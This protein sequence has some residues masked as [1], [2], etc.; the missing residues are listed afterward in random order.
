MKKKKPN[1]IEEIEY[2]LTELR[3]AVLLSETTKNRLHILRELPAAARASS[4]PNSWTNDLDKDIDLWT[5][6]I[7]EHERDRLNEIR[8]EL[9]DLEDEEK[10]R[11]I[12]MELD[13]DFHNTTSE[14][15][16]IVFNLRAQAIIPIEEHEIERIR[17]TY[18]DDKQGLSQSERIK[19]YNEAIKSLTGQ[20]WT[21][22]RNKIAIEEAEKLLMQEIEDFFD[23]IRTEISRTDG[24]LD[25]Q[26]ERC[27]KAQQELDRLSVPER[28]KQ[29]F[30]KEIQ[31]RLDSIAWEQDTIEITNH[32]AE[33]DPN[34]RSV[35]DMKPVYE[36][37]RRKL[38]AKE[39]TNNTEKCRLWE[40]VE[41]WLNNFGRIEES[42]RL[43]KIKPEI[44]QIRDELDAPSQVARTKEHLGELERRCIN[45]VSKLNPKHWKFCLAEKL[46]DE[47]EH[48][49]N[50]IVIEVIEIRRNERRKFSE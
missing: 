45:L 20:K 35:P 37:V 13:N 32:R 24:S 6:A 26:K 19:S 28:L 3:V 39:W 33:L 29:G 49:K 12:V 44:D 21:A 38:D 25:M 48:L 27:R 8:D 34:G 4:Q 47:A 17:T 14:N 9:E 31:E 41:N 11:E 1:N 36:D 7:E 40:E 15:R 18:L 50:R 5:S 22:V 10:M 46:L 23:P 42:E 43:D 30:G 2:L 16:V